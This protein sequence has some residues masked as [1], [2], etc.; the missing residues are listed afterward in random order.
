M[1][2]IP[3]RRGGTHLGRGEAAARGCETAEGHAPAGRDGGTAE[4]SK[5]SRAD[6]ASGGRS[7]S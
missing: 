2:N 6:N 7:V 1:L 4:P 5:A 3:G